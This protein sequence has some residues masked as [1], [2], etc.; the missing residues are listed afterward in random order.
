MNL[1]M[2]IARVQRIERGN[3]SSSEYD[4]EESDSDKEVEQIAVCYSN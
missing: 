3:E 4:S 1:A 2:D